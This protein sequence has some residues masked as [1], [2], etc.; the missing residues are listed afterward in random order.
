MG[1]KHPM[2]KAWNYIV[3]SMRHLGGPP[4]MAFA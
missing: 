4:P 2:R 3:E 1:R